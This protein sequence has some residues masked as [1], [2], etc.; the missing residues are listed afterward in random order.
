MKVLLVNCVYAFGSTGKI[1]KD[2]AGGLHES[3]VE[4]MIAYGRGSSIDEAWPVVKLTSEGIMKMQSFCSKLTGLS[5][6]CSPLSTQK[7]FKLIE[8]EKPDV[9]NLH[10]VNAN[11]INL[12]ETI[13]FLK[14][15]H[16]RTV[17]TIHAE[18]PYTGGCGYAYDCLQWQDGCR[19][20]PQFHEHDSQLPVSWF[21]NR[22]AAEWR[23][24]KKAYQDF[25][26][27]TVTCVSPWL[28]D[29]AK[30]SPFFMGR[31]ILPVLNG[32]DEEVF[33]P[34]DAERLRQKHHL[35]GKK[36]LL[37][38]TPN[39]YLS[40]KGGKYVLQIAQRLEGEHPNYAIIICGYR[41][42]GHDL[43]KNVIPIAFTQNQIELAEYYSLAN[44]TLLTSKRETFSMV[45]AE[46]LCCGTPLIGFNAGGPESIAL[47]E[48]SLFCDF[49]DV[50]QLYKNVVDVMSGLKELRFDAEKAR[51]MYSKETMKEAYKQVYEDLIDNC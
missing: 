43:P 11:T 35:V 8:Q 41:G 12:A 5:Y 2:I 34:R 15:K 44:A 39:F 49:G 7:L 31:K 18:F 23:E 17:L 33:Q 28:A 38:V 16:V 42:D 4:V 37:H 10:C 32:L 13:S 27:L 24:L 30:Q 9:V 47:K 36:V 21:L 25:N 29:R 40:I 48:G 51:K 14:K 26:E 19:R 46:S 22:T 50:E 20:C 6:G 1:I 3:G 45:T